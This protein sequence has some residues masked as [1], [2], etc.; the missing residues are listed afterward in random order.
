[1]A[2]WYRRSRYGVVPSS[3]P[4]WFLTALAFIAP[5][6]MI[7]AFI[8]ANPGMSKWHRDSLMAI[9]F[10]T[11]FLFFM[12][13]LATWADRSDRHDAEIIGRAFERRMRD[14][15]WGRT[16]PYAAGLWVRGVMKRLG[17]L[18]G[19][20]QQSLELDTA[21]DKLQGA[22]EAQER[23]RDVGLMAKLDR[24][25]V[26]GVELALKERPSDRSDAISYYR[27][28]DRVLHTMARG[29][30][31]RSL[32]GVG[33]ATRGALLWVA[34]VEGSDVTYRVYFV[35]SFSGEH[36]IVNE[37]ILDIRPFWPEDIARCAEALVG[38][39]NECTMITLRVPAASADG[40]T[41]NPRQGQSDPG[42]PEGGIH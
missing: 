13:V 8:D 28:F 23:S 3:W 30:R 18:S 14:D 37:R 21:V 27:F 5:A 11:I 2:G 26:E 25:V 34:R 9:A 6:F 20:Q 32:A 33:Y 4:G 7:A 15:F 19:R 39:A 36:V 31:V 12:V 41:A 40:R 10:L 42:V 35:Q 22:L 24:S 17:L 38:V 29:F 1:M 16:I